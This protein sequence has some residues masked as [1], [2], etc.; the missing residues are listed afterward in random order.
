MTTSQT[1]LFTFVLPLVG[2]FLLALLLID[3][4]IGKRDR[5]AQRSRLVLA[6]IVAVA[7]VGLI[8]WRVLA[9][10]HPDP[11][12]TQPQFSLITDPP[13]ETALAAET[14]LNEAEIPAFDSSDLQTPLGA[15]VPHP[16]APPLPSHHQVGDRLSF[17]LRG[18]PIEAELVHAN[19]S[20]YAWLA[21]GVE[22]DRDVI[23]AA[24]DRFAAEVLPALYPRQST[25][26]PR[27]DNQAIHVLNYEDPSD[28]KR[29]FFAPDTGLFNINLAAHGPGQ[30]SYLGT[31]ARELQHALHWHA[32]P[33]EER[34]LDEGLSDLAQQIVG[35]D[36]G[37]SDEVFRRAFDTQLNHWPYDGEGEPPAAPY[38]ASYRY[39]LYLWE[40]FG[41]TFVRDLVHHPANGLASVDAVLAA[42]TPKPGSTADT[43]FADWVVANAVDEG[44]FKYETRDWEASQP[45]W[46]EAT[47]YRYPMDIRSAVHPYATDYYRLENTHPSR[48]RFSGTTLTQLLPTKAHSGE[49]CWW[50]NAA[51]HSN[52]R[53]TRSVDLSALS[54]ATLGFW[55]WYD[56]ESEESRAYL[57]LSRDGRQTWTVLRTYDG[58]SDGWVEQQFDLTA[59]VGAPIELRFDYLTGGGAQDKGFL[60]DNLSIAELGLEDPCTEVGDWQAE[61]FV[62]AGKMVPVRWV[63]QVIDVYRPGHTL[64]VYRMS[65]DDKQTG[66]MEMRLRPLGGLL[67][68]QGRGIL[69]I[70]A[71]VR[72]TTEPLPYRCEIIRE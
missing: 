56:L 21:V 16:T 22:T 5:K 14:R 44:E 12:I 24:V 25:E 53:L 38:G 50:S 8:V 36:P 2:G 63:V 17:L 49:T 55:A 40:Q 39:L 41:E 6:G 19:S 29:S 59:F 69:A 45:T 28:G 18:R 20:I 66:E 11:Y 43:V 26:Q 34:W 32:D 23:R 62:L 3:L 54:Q 4:L 33:N 31:L 1:H 58:R 37:R 27:E 35:L 65:L 15:D 13:D 52:T 51:H 71:L 72:G 57:S 70:S 7:E 64:Q 61:G 9:T 30:A 67:G 10:S 48:I 68:N 46:Y 47:F 60:L 42:H